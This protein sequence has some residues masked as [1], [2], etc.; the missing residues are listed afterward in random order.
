MPLT[1]NEQVKRIRKVV[2][3]RLPDP[4]IKDILVV[5]TDLP[6]RPDQ[7]GYNAEALESLRHAVTEEMNRIGADEAQIIAV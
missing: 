4:N 3:L 7:A 5:E 2:G 6:L 1:D